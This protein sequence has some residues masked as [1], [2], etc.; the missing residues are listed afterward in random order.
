MTCAFHFTSPFRIGIEDLAT[1]IEDGK[2][3]GKSELF[4]LHLDKKIKHT[5]ITET[6]KT[7]YYNGQSLN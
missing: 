7:F 3:C 5:S 4:M 1:V 2:N 6:L